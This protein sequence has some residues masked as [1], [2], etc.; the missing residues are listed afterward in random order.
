MKK[1]EHSYQL[2][3]IN[4]IT[5]PLQCMDFCNKKCNCENLNSSQDQ[6]NCFSQCIDPCMTKNLNVTNEKECSYTLPDS[7][8]LTNQAAKTTNIGNSKRG[9]KIKKNRKI[10]KKSQNKKLRYKK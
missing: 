7:Q 2:S 9:K 8:N 6:S 4:D 3:N 10:I 1:R 5:P